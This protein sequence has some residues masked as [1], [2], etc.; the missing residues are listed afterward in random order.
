MRQFTY[1]GDHEAV[2]LWG[3]A[4]P[5]GVAV[6]VDAPHALMKLQGNNH[7]AEVISGVEVVTDPVVIAESAQAQHKRRGRPPKAK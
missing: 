4:F 6:S 1:L 3:I 2:T 5:R 7:F